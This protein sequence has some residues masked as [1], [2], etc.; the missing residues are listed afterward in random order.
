M[1]RSGSWE[2]MSKRNSSSLALGQSSSVPLN[3]F[4]SVGCH[5]RYV[6]IL[7]VL[8]NN[9]C[10]RWMKEGSESMMLPAEP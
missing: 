6:S 5:H 10:F 9:S 7:G 3:A 8:A 1:I 4:N 2:L